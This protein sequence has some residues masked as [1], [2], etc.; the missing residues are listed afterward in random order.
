MGSSAKRRYR[1]TSYNDMMT[2]APKLPEGARGLRFGDWA[3]FL[4]IL[5]VLFGLLWFAA[6]LM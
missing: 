6:S 1:H 3:I 4:G 5:A 2:R